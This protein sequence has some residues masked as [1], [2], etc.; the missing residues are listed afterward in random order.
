[1]IL[2]HAS[3]ALRWLVVVVL[4]LCVAN[5]TSSADEAD[6]AGEAGEVVRSLVL[7]GRLQEASDLIERSIDQA[8]RPLASLHYE[9]STIALRLGKIEQAW[10][11]VAVAK[12]L[13][14]SVYGK[15]EYTQYLARRR[16]AVLPESPVGQCGAYVFY[17]D[18]PAETLRRLVGRVGELLPAFQTWFPLADA[19][20]RGRY[21]V[22]VY[23]LKDT[24]YAALGGAALKARAF[25]QRCERAVFVAGRHEAQALRLVGHEVFHAHAHRLIEQAPAWL[26]EGFADWFAVIKIGESGLQARPHPL[27]ARDFAAL[28]RSGYDV[29][30][31][32]FVGTPRARIYGPF[33][34]AAWGYIAFMLDSQ[35]YRPH[36][37]SYVR[38]VLAGQSPERAF[39]TGFAG[40]RLSELEA[41]A[42]DWVMAQRH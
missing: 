29:R 34:P 30:F 6:E 27:R 16:H 5:A 13:E 25:Y 26:D 20:A 40:L 12:S 14:P 18:C 3:W 24:S 21:L 33:Y 41:A 11:H 19:D 9:A 36:L 8:P 37:A 31:R 7:A 42:R 17:S 15:T 22:R 35:R 10:R 32:E 2:R 38:A 1:M 28:L 39:Q 4:A 23:V